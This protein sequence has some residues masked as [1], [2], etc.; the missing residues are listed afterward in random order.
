MVATLDFR[1]GQFWLLLIYVASTLLTK[2]ILLTKFW[3]N[4]P[5]GSEEVQNRFLKWQSW[6]Q[7]GICDCN[8]F[9]YIFIYRMSKHFLPNFESFGLLI[10]EKRHKTDFQD[11][12]H[13]G[14]PNR[15]ILAIFYLQVARILPTKFWVNWPFGSEEVQNRFSRWMP[16]HPSC[17]SY[18]NN[19]SFFWSTTVL[20]SYQVSS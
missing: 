4:W 11:G 10:W 9:S 14:F 12:A 17:I 16:M 15:T 19:V 18:Q 20:S 8:D 2:S 1:S 3:V 6:C 13:L 5:F 7:S